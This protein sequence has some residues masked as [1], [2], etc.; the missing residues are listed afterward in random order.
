[1]TFI[2]FAFA[3]LQKVQYTKILNVIFAS[4]IHLIICVAHWF[5]GNALNLI[6]EVTLCQTQLL[7]HW[8]QTSHSGQLT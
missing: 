5:I 1:M 4:L 2:T 6:N 7:S 3:L 8:V